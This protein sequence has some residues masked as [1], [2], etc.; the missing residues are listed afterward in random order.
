MRFS[1]LGPLRVEAPGGIVDIDRPRWRSVLAYLLLRADRLVTTEQ[2]VAAVWGGDPVRTAA[3]QVHTAISAL[4]RTF[5]DAGHP[6]LIRSR[7]AGYTL[8]VAPDRLD[9]AG[10]GAAAAAAG[11]AGTGDIA[12]LRRALDLWRG[13]AFEGIDGSFV[14]AARTRLEEQRLS[15]FE[16]LMDLEI[17]RGNHRD[18]TPELMGYL[19]F[20][21][22]RE[23]L[24]ERLIRALYLSGRKSDALREYMRIRQRLTAELGVEP[25]PELRG[26]HLEILQDAPV[27]RPRPPPHPQPATGP[28]QLPPPSKVFTGRA[29]ER[30]QLRDALSPPAGGA[31]PIV[32]LHG[33]GGA[34]K[35]TLAIQV[36]Y[37]LGAVYPDGQLYVDLQGSSPG[38]VPLTPLEILRR[39]LSGLGRPEAE[40][41]TDAAAAARE[42]TQLSAGSHFLVLLDNA[43][44]PGQVEPVLRACRSGAV[45]IT[46][47]APLALS[48]LALSLRLDVLPPAD[49]ISLLDRIAGRGGADWSEF[50]RIAAYCDYLPLALCIAGGR[51]AREPDLSGSRLAASLADH[52]DRLDTLEV[53]GVGVR[54]SIRVG[55]D[56]IASG[57][58]PADGVAAAAFCVLGLLPLPTVDAGLIAAVLCPDDPPLAA[59]ALSRLARAQLIGADGDGR[60]R[61]HDMVRAVAGG[62]AEETI[63]V[64]RRA[65]LRGRGFAYY[66]GCALLADDLLRPTRKGTTPRPDPYDLVPRQVL[67]QV[68]RGPDDVGGWLDATLP[69]LV[70]AVRLAAADGDTAQ[71]AVTIAKA[72]S[73]VL[74]KRGEHHREHALAESAVAAAEGLGQPGTLR[75]ALM[76]LGRVELYLTEYDA[77]LGHLDRALESARA[78]GDRY[79][80]LSTLNDLSLAAIKRDDLPGARRLLRECI[81]LCATIPE[82]ARISAIPIHNLAA[83]EALLGQWRAAA[84]LLRRGLPLRLAAKD[85]AGEGT[86]LILL[87]TIGCG[88]GEL[89]EAATHLDT[90]IGI[91][92]SIGDRVDGWFGLAAL[93]LVQLRQGRHLEAVAV[94]QRC[95]RT[96]RGIDQPFAEKCAHRL[97]SLAHTAA[98]E[99]GDARVHARGAEAIDAAPSSLEARLIDV[100]L[101]GAGG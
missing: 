100:L 47:R 75:R 12:E 58:G 89:D 85:R 29:A 63:G 67:Q 7:S 50:S 40:I 64:R 70:A 92:E 28:R 66:A 10:F 13:Q 14:A 51:L 41:P 15:V 31:R 46:G 27:T 17:A 99:P 33:S 95:L 90:G 22:L 1:V 43:T 86:D 36:A 49:A 61:P 73:W 101:T 78:D 59:T 81:D 9:L 87:G 91:C 98:G 96:A 32:A 34:G 57:S 42:Y 84:E 4:R 76:Q 23:S 48:D 74:R 20:H 68:L 79:D 62:Y 30:A 60:Y 16:A 83:V 55:Y 24:V 19:E 65:E 54:S 53:D 37:D 18:I 2:I 6:D 25:G 97:L 80:Q 52:R 77:A 35:S 72:L 8:S 93:T 88:L 26:L 39:L 71:H 38:L 82:G 69:N 5:R 21:P 56:L 44:D 45:I 94:G 3:T 11:T